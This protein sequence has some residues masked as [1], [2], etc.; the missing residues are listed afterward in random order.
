MDHMQ[1]VLEQIQRQDECHPGFNFFLVKGFKLQKRFDTD[2][3]EWAL[4]L[5]D[6][7]QKMRSD[8][9]QTE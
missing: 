1:K 7:S 6:I 5:I 4:Q 8:S 3:P 2:E 9:V